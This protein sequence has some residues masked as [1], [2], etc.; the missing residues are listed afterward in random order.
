MLHDRESE[1]GAAHFAGAAFFHPV[2]PLKNPLDVLRRDA[3]AVVLDFDGNVFFVLFEV[4][5]YLSISFSLF[6][7]L[8][9]TKTPS[10]SS[11]KKF[12]FKK[13]TLILVLR[14][15]QY[16]FLIVKFGFSPPVA[17]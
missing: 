1:T 14:K 13:F 11:R 6:I 10:D 8:K 16:Y 12:W 4:D 17:S 3:F 7:D 5:F 2:K 15:L 9:K